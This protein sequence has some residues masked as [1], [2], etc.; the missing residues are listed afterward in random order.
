MA[1]KVLLRV[2]PGKLKDEEFLDKLFE[3]ESSNWTCEDC[4]VVIQLIMKHAPR[5]THCPVCKGDM[6]LVAMVLEH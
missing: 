3:C 6:K 4:E 5:E 2:P 1:E